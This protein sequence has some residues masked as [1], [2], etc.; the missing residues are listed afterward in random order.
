MLSG[1]VANDEAWAVRRAAVQ[2]LA[3]LDC[4][5]QTFVAAAT[6]P[7]WRVRHE[8]LNVIIGQEDSVSNRTDIISRIL[9]PASQRRF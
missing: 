6:D 3:G 4:G 9:V 2:C 8:F 7:H 5:T 1:L